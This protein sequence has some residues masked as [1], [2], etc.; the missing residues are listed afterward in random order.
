MSGTGQKL[1]LQD[2]FKNLTTKRSI[3]IIAL[4]GIIV[5]FNSLFNDFVIDDNSQITK[6]VLVH[7]IFN[8]PSFFSGSTFYGGGKLIGIYYKPVTLGSFSLIYNT[9]GPSPVWFHLFQVILH[10]TNASILF[11][12]FKHFFSKPISLVLAL[13]FL[14]HPINS[15]SVFYISN[16]QEVLFFLFGIIALWLL[17]N[18]QLKKYF[19]LM[20]LFLFLSILSK[21]TGILFFFI[22]II[23]IFLTRKQ[24]LYSLLGYSTLALTL[25]FILRVNAVGIFNQ[26]LNAPIASTSLPERLINIPAILFF[27]L[28]T[29][30]VPINLASSYQWVYREISFNHFF[31]P[32]VIDIVAFSII[33]LVAF[34]LYRTY[35]RKYFDTYIF[36]GI[37]FFSGLFIHLQ[38][39]PLD[40]TVAERWFYFP[41][42][43][44]LGMMGIVMQLY[45]PRSGGKWIMIA[46]SAVILVFLSV[47]TIIRSFDWRDDYILATRDIRVSKNS[48]NLEHRIS[49]ALAKQGKF[50]EAK[51][52]AERSISMYPYFTNYNN[53][54]S[55]YLNLKEFEKAKQAY[56]EALQFGDYYAIYENLGLLALVYGDQK[57]NVEFINDAL[58]KFPQNAKLWLHLAILEYKMNNINEAKIAVHQA[59]RYSKTQDILFVYN[60]I[61][62]EQPLNLNVTFEY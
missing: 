26:P 31:L 55:I 7:S 53:L 38:I 27:Y 28:K 37:W 58:I 59:Y 16:M 32:L 48:Y 44:L 40:A 30:L 9:F 47:R 42:V 17:V 14:V 56:L 62:N 34:K 25:Y 51:I 6:N 22:S 45:K 15:E 1:S 46:M 57:E 5:F 4:V 20:L 35:P 10:I 61:M 52:H 50:E 36:F 19:V 24:R 3:V 39:L 21:E 13:V 54:G 11:L 12:L 29:F 2:F 41:I 33:I 60:K 18:F 23:Y 43:G 49:Y 8:I